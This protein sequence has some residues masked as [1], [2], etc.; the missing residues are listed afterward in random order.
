MNID[1]K[2]DK[3]AA[4]VETEWRKTAQFLMPAKLDADFNTKGG[5]NIYPACALGEGKIFNGFDSLAKYII[6]QKTVVIDGY[7]G[8]FLIR[9]KK[10]Y[11][12]VLQ[13]R[14]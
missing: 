3:R 1:I 6:G 11:R 13:K 9:Y 12:H 7:A 8:V 5:Y 4:G 10:N 2:N 14:A